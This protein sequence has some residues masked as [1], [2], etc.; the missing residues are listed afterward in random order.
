M[1]CIMAPESKY[2]DKF[3]IN[4]IIGWFNMFGI[5][6]LVFSTKAV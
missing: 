5:R 4:R 1:W 3:F 6:V 2:M